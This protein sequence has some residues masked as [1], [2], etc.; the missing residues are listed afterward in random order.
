MTHLVAP[1]QTTH[2]S[3]RQTQGAADAD[4]L[5]VGGLTRLTTIDYPGELAAVVFCQGC[6]WRCRYCHNGDLLDAG[7]EGRIPWPEVL[8]FLEQRVGLLDAVVFSGGEP[9][10]Q[11]ALGAAMREARSLGYK[12]GLHTSGAYPERLRPL[13]DLIDWVGL[14][15]KA[16]PQDYP[17]IT[18]VA[19]SGERAWTSLDLL[20]NAGTP[21]E[22]RTTLMPDW[23]PRQVAD[24]GQALSKAGVRH[25]ALQVCDTRRALDPSLSLAGLPVRRLV[26][27]LDGSGF[28][29]FAVRGDT[30]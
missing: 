9:T 17:A 22:V 4:N 21:L 25:Y 2:P 11:G 1:T 18:G 6:P 5:R 24:L 19:G 14:D 30:P 7:G 16:L 3:N 13:L 20:L 27:S 26:E 8:R 12:I 15:I 23:T 10:A 29:R 28:D